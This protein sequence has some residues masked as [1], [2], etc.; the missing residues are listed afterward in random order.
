L[1]AQGWTHEQVDAW[2]VQQ[3]EGKA[4]LAKMKFSEAVLERAMTE[5]GITDREAFLT[6]AVAFDAEGNNYLNTD[7]LERAARWFTGKGDE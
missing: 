1:L 6:Y 4:A 2:K 7:E 5:H 3:Q